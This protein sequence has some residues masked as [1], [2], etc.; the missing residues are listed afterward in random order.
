MFLDIKFFLSNILN[1]KRGNIISVITF[2]VGTF[3]VLCLSGTS[4]TTFGIDSKLKI[5]LYISSFLYFAI[6]LILNIRVSSIKRIIKDKRIHRPSLFSIAYISICFLTILSFLFNSDKTANVNTYISF[7]VTISLTYFILLRF[8]KLF[9][10]KCFKNI[11]CTLCILSLTIFLITQVSETFFSTIYYSNENIIFGSFGFLNTDFISGLTYSFKWKLRLSGIFWEPSVLGSMLICALFVDYLTKDK[12]TLFRSIIFGICIILSSSTTAF[13]LALLYFFMIIVDSLKKHRALQIVIFVIAMIFLIVFLIFLEQIL[14]FLALTLPSVFGKFVDSSSIVS[15]TTRLYSFKYYF[16]VFL[17]NPIFGVGGVS[18][19]MYYDELAGDLVTAGTSTFGLVIASFGVAG[20]LFV[21][22]I[23]VGLVLNEKI[24]WHNKVIIIVVVLLL[25]NAQGQSSILMIMLL[26]F[27]PLSLVP[28]SKSQLEVRSSSDDSDI[29][30]R[31]IVFS[32]T[33][34]GELSSNLLFSVMIKG[35][36]IVLAFFTVPT[37]LKYFNYSD[38][39]YGIWLTI[40]SVLALVTVFDFGMGNGL[41]NALIKNINSKAYSLSKKY[42]ST[43]YAITSII[44]LLIPVVFSSLIFCLSN[45]SLVNLFFF[46]QSITLK[47]LL[48]FRIG[49]TLIMCAIGGQFVLKNINYILQAHQKN[50]ISSLFMLITNACLLVFAGSF[51]NIVDSSH[52]IITL[53][54]MYLVFL[55]GP[56]LI[57]SIILFASKYRRYMPSFRYIDFKNSKNVVSTGFKFFIVQIGSLFLWSANEFI[58][59]FVFKDSALVT[60]YSEYYRLF[61]LFPIILGTVIQQPIWTAMSKADIQK[62]AKKLSQLIKL[63]TIIT[64]TTVVINVCLVFSVSFVFDIWLGNSSPS[65]TYAQQIVFGVYSL[66]YILTM[67]LVIICNAFSLFRAQIISASLAVAAKIPIIIA[68]SL[69]PNL[70][71]TWEL[72]ILINMLCY[73]PTVIISPF[74]INNYLK[75]NHNQS[76]INFYKK[77]NE[78]SNFSEIQI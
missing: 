18:A 54:V 3:F 28:T 70:Y 6:L 31:N 61:S 71:L 12:L 66:I 74:E 73:L 57:A 33:E 77:M 43:T 19:N 62:N 36:S 22:S 46:N 35:I 37:Y 38:S 27:M 39:T 40:T 51:A 53:S 59:L 52:K 13:V 26:Y 14:S 67:G 60:T 29:K 20:I 10:I 1:K 68:L 49:F 55:N 21:I 72:I 65:V 11:L 8:N 4:F 47:G 76:F 48:E 7:L 2:L 9:I 69:I 63:L 25:S 50:A 30:I 75:R 23:F 78:P 64:I 24:C 34:N 15:F 42:V 58:I 44:G 5:T 32:K 41:K 16:D 45:D 17:K 56:L